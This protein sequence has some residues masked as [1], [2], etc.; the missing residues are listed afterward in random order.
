M[1]ISG[2]SCIYPPIHSHSG[3]FLRSV[4]PRHE[5][6]NIFSLTPWASEKTMWRDTANNW[7]N[8]ISLLLSQPFSQG[9]SLP[10]LLKE[11]QGSFYV[12]IYDPSYQRSLESLYSPRRHWIS[13]LQPLSMD[14]RNWF[15]QQ[16]PQTRDR[17][18]GHPAVLEDYPLELK[19]EGGPP[20]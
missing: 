8:K 15:G 7:R 19:P 3:V 5:D 10:L 9:L 2:D 6:L 20:R 1:N 13:S 17:R 14:H 11:C 16:S 18:P 4:V 12:Y